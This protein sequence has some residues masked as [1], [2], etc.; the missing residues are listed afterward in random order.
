M[1]ILYHCA[2]VLIELGPLAA[3]KFFGNRCFRLTVLMT[4]RKKHK[5]ILRG[6]SPDH[7]VFYTVFVRKDY[8]RLDVGDNPLILD[9]GANVGYSALWF[10]LIYKNARLICVE[11]DKTNY[12]V[13]KKNTAS[14]VNC[15]SIMSAV[16]GAEGMGVRL[17]GDNSIS[18]V[19]YEDESAC[20]V[21]SVD[22]KGLLDSEPYD[23]SSIIVKMDI[24]GAEKSVFQ[25]DTEWLKRVDW[26][27]IEIHKNCWKDVFRVLCQ[28]DF[29]C[30]IVGETLI[31]DLRN[32]T[33]SKM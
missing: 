30:R 29:T 26:L 3:V 9:L 1:I 24:E 32:Y 22:I 6:N 21:I 31:V 17:E 5:V 7:H 19:A 13:L 33:E 15:N 2:R 12:S 10:A 25:G 20:E 28:G 23:A 4:L 27:Y 18:F 16:M 11:P 8:P 14:I